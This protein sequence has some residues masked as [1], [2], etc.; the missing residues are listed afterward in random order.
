[1]YLSHSM[2]IIP[3]WVCVCLHKFLHTPD[4]IIWTLYS[5]SIPV[6]AQNRAK[7]LQFLPRVTVKYIYIMMDLIASGKLNVTSHSACSG[8][9]SSDTHLGPMLTLWSR[10]AR[11][12][13]FTIVTVN[14]N[15]CPFVVHGATFCVTFSM[16]CWSG[17]MCID[18][19]IP[20]QFMLWP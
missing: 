2:F 1:M 7:T 12:H 15:H 16:Y 10:L 6:R 9:L 3:Y 8:F 20:E 4:S 18:V 19:Q 17:C 13:K 11:L 14:I 5:H